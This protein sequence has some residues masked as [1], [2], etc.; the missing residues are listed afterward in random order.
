MP[1][2]PP[3]TAYSPDLRQRVVLVTGATGG[4]GQHIA[5]ACAAAGATVALHGRVVRK[6][7][8]LYD[9]IVAAGH[10]EPTILPLDFLRAG[11]AE[12][13]A[14]ANAIESQLGRLDAIVHTAAFLGSLGPLEHQ[15]FERWQEVLRVNVAGAMGMTRAVSPLLSKAPDASVVFTLD[16]RGV[17]PRA[18]WGAYAA[19]KAAIQALATTLAD[20][21]EA[22]ANVRVN[23]ITPGPMRSPLRTL[24]HPGEEKVDLPTPDALVPLYLY[25]VAGQP[26]D[27]S[28]VRIDA[29]AW[30]AG[31]PCHDPTRRRRC[32]FFRSGELR[33]PQQ[34][35]QAAEILRAHC[36]RW[37][38]DRARQPAAL[39]PPYHR[40]EPA[41]H[42]GRVEHL[43]DK[44]ASIGVKHAAR[45]I[46]SDDQLTG[47]ATTRAHDLE[48]GEEHARPRERASRPPWASAGPA[49]RIAVNDDATRRDGE[50]PWGTASG[51]AQGR[52]GLHASIGRRAR[53]SANRPDAR[54]GEQST[55]W[56]FRCGSQAEARPTNRTKPSSVFM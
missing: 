19:S 48:H 36:S 17:A 50:Q 18:Y 22:R 33:E 5:R 3:S 55:A 23:A 49:S 11:A 26:K 15:S 14:V 24:T 53:V 39:R 34:D 41:C 47:R 13:Y 1:L 54:G 7:E 35:A 32:V 25:L 31:Q 16:T 51:D 29:A 46:Q 27:E 30:L 4:L 8:A 12:F 52:D 10:P 45:A 56:V 9:E 38:R 2:P 44:D 37:K 6:L 40:R 43:P 28:G 20:E 21:W 42:V